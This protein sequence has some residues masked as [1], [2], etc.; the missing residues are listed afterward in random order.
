MIAQSRRDT[1]EMHQQA[2]IERLDEKMAALLVR[3]EQSEAYRLVAA[4]DTHPRLVAGIIQQ[5]LLEVFSYGPHVTE[6]TFTAI[7]RL[8]K[9]RP[10]LMKAMIRHDLSEV[11]HGEMALKDF[12]N[13]GSPAG[14]PNGSSLPV[15]ETVSRVGTRALK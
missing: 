11:D 8:P 9:N 7:G 1:T 13:F 12:I 6:A 15:S 10:D 14:M 4:P 2:F 3:I 5:I